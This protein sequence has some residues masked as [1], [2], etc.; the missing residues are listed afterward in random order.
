MLRFPLAERQTVPF[1]DDPDEPELGQ[2]LGRL[3]EL[4]E[5]HNDRA[6]LAG[7]IEAMLRGALRHVIADAPRPWLEVGCGA[8]TAFH[9]LGYPE[10]VIG[11]DIRAELLERC[12]ERHPSADCIQ[13]DLLRSPFRPGSIRTLFSIFSLEHIFELDAFVRALH[14]LLHPKGRLH[15]LIPAEGAPGWALLR[16]AAH[17]VYTPKL[18]YSYKRLMAVEHCNSAPAVECA[19]NKRFHVE[20]R[21][22]APLGLGGFACNL[23]AAYRLRPR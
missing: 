15:V 12:K 10:A 4:S 23:A 21:R 11:L 19:L 22:L 20:A 7:R 8:G 9:V 16:Q 17:W 3:Y 6:G 18:G 1:Y 5:T 13:A 14:G 2:A